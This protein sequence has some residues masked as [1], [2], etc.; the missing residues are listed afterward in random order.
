MALEL[1]NSKDSGT[2]LNGVLMNCDSDLEIGDNEA[3]GERW[4]VA[5]ASR[6]FEEVEFG[7][8]DVSLVNDW[9]S[10]IGASRSGL[11]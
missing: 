8:G 4:G 9:C 5:E 2:L 10:S 3:E 7:V 1:P 11:K 6:Q